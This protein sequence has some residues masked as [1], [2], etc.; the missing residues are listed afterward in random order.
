MRTAS[1]PSSAMTA[2]SLSALLSSLGTSSANVALPAL[3]QAFD[4]SFQAVQ[5]VVL[6]YLLAMTMLVVVAGRLGDLFGRRRLLVAGLALFTGASL[7]CAVAPTLPFLV[8]ARAA[9]G[10]GAAAMTAL[11]MALVAETMPAARA[12]SAMGLLGT[13]SAIGT[14]LGPTLAGFVMSAFGWRA[15]FL[16]NLP[17]GLLALFLAS[18]SL[19]AV[20][21]AQPAAQPAFD[22]AGMVLLALTIAAYSLAATVRT[23][24]IAVAVLGLFLFLRTELR[25]ASPL[26]RLAMFR[27]PLISAGFAMSAVVTT[28]VMATLV[29]GP[30]YLSR[31]L[32]LGAAAVGAAMSAGPVLAALAGVPSG[33][34]VDRFGASTMTLSGL[35]V[36]AL[37]STALAMIPASLGVW[38]YVVPLMAITAGYALFQAAN[39]TAVM[40]GSSPA[41]R[42]VISGLLNL[43]RNLGLVT[44]ASAM[45]SVFAAGGMR[46][47]FALAAALL[48]GAMLIREFGVRTRTHLPSVS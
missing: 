17:L 30:F 11:A 44:G 41:E 15:I 6:S 9:Q 18:R 14:A 29:V 13:M 33:R 45:G 7:L 31:S 8:A 48:V 38:G 10:L 47:T 40:A 20:G 5:W 36:M 35:A 46:V 32:G 4:A 27:N 43:S 37:G 19:G 25:A 39:N 26:I 2:L 1:N 28:V 23:D 42:G 24:L 22:K 16:V 21:R 3:V 12:G 34:L